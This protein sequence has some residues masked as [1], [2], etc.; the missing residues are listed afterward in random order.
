[1]NTAQRYTAFQVPGA[2]V[3]AAVLFFVWAITGWPMVWAVVAWIAWIVKDV[4]MYPVVR[5]AYERRMPPHADRLV[6][7]SGRVIERLA[8]TGR[9]RVA[10]ESW[11]ASVGDDDAPID[12][13]GRVRVVAVEGLRLLVR[14]DS[15]QPTASSN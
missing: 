4:A 10:G 5:S 15:D 9:V 6:E 2:I 13:G 12:V 8:P 11:L 3:F 1:M 14:R 7:K